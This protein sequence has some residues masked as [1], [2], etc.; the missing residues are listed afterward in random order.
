MMD[1][2]RQY[3]SLNDLDLHLWLQLY[4][5]ENCELT[6]SQTFYFIDLVIQIGEGRGGGGGR[7]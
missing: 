3:T 2:T 4:E 6:F 7:G 1:I 5:K